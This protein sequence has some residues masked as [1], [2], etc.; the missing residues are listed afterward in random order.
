MKQ[1]APAICFIKLFSTYRMP[2]ERITTWDSHL[3]PLLVIKLLVPP[4]SKVNLV[5]ELTPKTTRI[6]DMQNSLVSIKQAYT[7]FPHLCPNPSHKWP[8]SCSHHLLTPI[9]FLKL[10]STCTTG[11]LAIPPP[12]CTD[13]GI[14]SILLQT[15]HLNPCTSLPLLLNAI[16]L[17]NLFLRTRRKKK[18]YDSL[19]K[20]TKKSN[21]EATHVFLFFCFCFLGTSH[22]PLENKKAMFAN[23]ISYSCSQKQPS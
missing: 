10:F 6:K 22:G 2:N 13:G 16:P 20:Q 23:K 8:P 9:R 18:K 21:E 14:Y 19:H 5:P 1:S 7:I 15:H 3:Q 12:F 4:R 11:D 17:S